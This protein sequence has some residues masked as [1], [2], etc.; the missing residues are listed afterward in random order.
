MATFA[1]KFIVREAY[2]HESIALDWSIVHPRACNKLDC[3]SD[4]EHIV[5]CPQQ[6]PKWLQRESPNMGWATEQQG[7]HA[8]N[9]CT[10]ARFFRGV[11]ILP[12]THPKET[13]VTT[14][15]PLERLAVWV[16]TFGVGG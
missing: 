5:D 9:C 11:E 15:I 8:F 6:C 4:T 1:S 10:P 12:P 3:P 2:A 13:R 7:M 14:A 16:L